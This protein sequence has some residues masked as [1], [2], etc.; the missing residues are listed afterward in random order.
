MTIRNPIVLIPG[1]NPQF[2]ELPAGDSIGGAAQGPVGMTWQG[3]WNSGTSYAIDDVVSNNGSAYIAIAANTNQAPPNATYWNLLASKGD[4]GATGAKG[5]T[6]ATGA[7]GTNGTNGAM[8]LLAHAIITSGTPTTIS[9][10]SLSGASNHLKI[11]F[12]MRDT[13]SGTS[14]S[15][16]RMFINSDTT[17]ANYTTT[18]RSGTLG[19][20]GFTSA[21]AASTAGIYAGQ[22]PNG[23]NTAGSFGTGEI[24]IYSYAD[25]GKQKRMQM[26]ASEIDTTNGQIVINMAAQWLST[27]A[28]TGVTF[29]TAGTALAVNS[30]FW[31]YGF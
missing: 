10:S 18:T 2:Q 16:L 21:I 4:T 6:G 22:I 23:G 13:A 1:G 3:A 29:T 8:A 17:A 28:V 24:T 31:V 27:A 7:A 9:V 26:L 30:E 14:G 15:N 5:D 20:T 19:T 11:F 12:S 25:T